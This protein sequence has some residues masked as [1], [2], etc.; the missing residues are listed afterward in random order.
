MTCHSQMVF[1]KRLVKCIRCNLE[2]VNTLTDPIY[3]A[4]ADLYPN[5]HVILKLLLTLLAGHAHVR[6]IQ[7]RLFGVSR[8]GVEQQ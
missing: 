5:V 8:L 4:D 7:S 6:G 1:Y 2:F 3:Y